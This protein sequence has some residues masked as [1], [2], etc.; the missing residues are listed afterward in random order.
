[1]TYEKIQLIQGDLSEVFSLVDQAGGSVAALEP[2]EAIEQLE[3]AGVK[4]ENV[5]KELSGELQCH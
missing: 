1:M 3:L 2:A 5:I 4:I